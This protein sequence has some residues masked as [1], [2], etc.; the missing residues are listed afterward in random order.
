MW[1]RRLKD[2]PAQKDGHASTT[3]PTA[4]GPPSVANSNGNFSWPR[5]H[6]AR[7]AATTC[8]AAAFPRRGPSRVGFVRV[9]FACD[10]TCAAS[11]AEQRAPAQLDENR[12][13]GPRVPVTNPADR[14]PREWGGSA[15]VLWSSLKGTALPR[16]EVP[17]GTGMFLGVRDDT[18]IVVP[19]RLRSSSRALASLHPK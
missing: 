15:R 7:T 12:H 6:R 19:A 13:G 5:N 17:T 3:Q 2:R 10:F 1:C 8:I 9:S 18:W 16:R 11:F 4:L 14:Q